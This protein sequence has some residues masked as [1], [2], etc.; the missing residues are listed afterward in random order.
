MPEMSGE[1]AEL[2]VDSGAAETVIH[3]DMLSSLL[4]VEDPTKRRGVH[5]EVAS[6]VRVSNLGE[7]TRRDDDQEEGRRDEIGGG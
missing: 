2:F 5:Y 1:E 6:A 4:R 7:E 3:E